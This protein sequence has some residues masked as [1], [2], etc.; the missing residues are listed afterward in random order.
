MRAITL[1]KKDGVNMCTRSVETQ[2]A[3][4]SVLYIGSILERARGDVSMVVKSRD[5]HTVLR[6]FRQSGSLKCLFPRSKD[7]SLEVVLLNCAG[8][9]TGGDYFSLSV[10]CEAKTTL[11]LTTQAA[12]RIYR[13]VPGETGCIETH[14]EVH[15]GARM[16]WLPQETI[17]FEGCSLNRALT[18]DLHHNSKLLMVEPLVFGR[19]EMGEEIDHVSVIDGITINRSDQPIHI[20]RIK[21]SSDVQS[22]LDR[23][24]VAMGAR[25]LASIVY[26]APDAEKQLNSTYQLFPQHAG[27][28][29]IQSDVLIMRLIANDSN[30]LR[31]KLVP[32]IKQ[33]NNGE[34]PKCWMI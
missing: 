27:A 25:A 29:L 33:I 16:N 14:L 5:S 24:G 18:I 22:H 2:R 7:K 32:I 1:P 30:E 6:N 31:L 4:S 3:N 12:E 19:L 11:T 8:G 10:N 15:E 26:I 20:E 9:V 21:L 34:I 28:S 17:L 13:A 23:P